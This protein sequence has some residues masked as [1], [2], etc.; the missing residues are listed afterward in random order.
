MTCSSWRGSRRARRL[1]GTTLA[2]G[3]AILALPATSA[4]AATITVNTTADHAPATGEC[5][6]TAGDCSLRQALDKAV[7]GDT[8]KVPANTTS[9]KVTGSPITIP[10]GVRI[11]GGG[12]TKTTVTGGG[13]NQIFVYNNAAL[14]PAISISR[15][16]LTD[17]F[18]N[19]GQDEGGAIYGE[20]NGTLI[21]DQVAVTHSSSPEYGGGFEGGGDLTLIRS[22]F[23]HDSDGKSGGGGIDFYG[24]K[25][26]ITDS[27]FSNDTNSGNVG[28]GGVISELGTFAL[29]RVTFS[30]D[31]SAIRGGGFYAEGSGTLYN[32]TFTANSAPEGGG[33]VV[34]ATTTA[35]ND[36][37]AGNSSANG[38]NLRVDTGRTLAVQNSIFARPSGGPSCTSSG[39]ITDNG[40]NLEDASTSSC[41]F[42][43]AKHDIIG[44]SADLGALATNGSKVAAAGGAPQTLALSKHSAALH[45][46]A[47]SGCK[48]VGSVDE[49]KMKRPGLAGTGCDIGAFELQVSKPKVS[50][51]RPRNH[52]H[53]AQGAVVEAKYTCKE[54]KNGPGIK[55]CK[56]TVRSGHAI[57]TKTLGKHTFKV[58]AVSKDGLKATRTITYTVVKPTS[59]TSPVFTG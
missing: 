51:K 19:T 1:W 13:A 45:T 2:L 58:T 38:A 25:L 5:S 30:H 24:D 12:A 48:T 34:A 20:D 50:I 4:A 49:R 10:N 39:T 3:A 29:N 14:T 37:F 54:G 22:S 27:S 40:N 55:T 43:T 57:N 7:A 36:T 42:T 59:T 31:T 6:G 32:S 9:Y 18:N 44:K 15:M 52:A 47:A 46:A 35:V 23:S 53:Y 17:G 11:I 26:T 41:G 16:T 28:G 21:L 56:G 8:V 33:L